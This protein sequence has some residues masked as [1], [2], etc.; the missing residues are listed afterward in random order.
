MLSFRR[1]AV[2]AALAPVLAVLTGS[3]S[4]WHAAPDSRTYRI[5]FQQAPPRQY[6]DGS[7]DPYGSLIDLLEGA[8]LRSHVKL[9]WVL[10]PEG[11]D[12]AF[13]RGQGQDWGPYAPR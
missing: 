11:P 7:G 1:T 13:D 10:V 3:C 12:V 2:A 5:G 6:V 8:A 4:A 9:K